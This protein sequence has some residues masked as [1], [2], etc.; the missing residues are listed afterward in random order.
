MTQDSSKDYSIVGEIKAFS[1]HAR[2]FLSEI[3][4][5]FELKSEVVP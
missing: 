4:P 2:L 5:L 3:P 1:M